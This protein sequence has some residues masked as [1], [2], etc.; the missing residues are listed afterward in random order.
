MKQPALYRMQ[1]RHLS[2]EF[3]ILPMIDSPP[4]SN[5][6]QVT[7]MLG[8]FIHASMWHTHRHIGQ[9]HKAVIRTPRGKKPLSGCHCRW[10]KINT[11]FK[12]TGGECMD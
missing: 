1:N 9:E 5:I 11:E 2:S 12:E 8:T 3:L 10:D 6:C 7:P 4:L